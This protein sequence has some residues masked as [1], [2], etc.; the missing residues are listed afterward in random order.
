MLNAQLHASPQL[1]GAHRRRSLEG[2]QASASQNL[3]LTFSFPA[4]GCCLSARGFAGAELKK[5]RDRRDRGDG[6][7]VQ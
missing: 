4:V 3:L 1:L 5:A 7:V 2:L 6:F